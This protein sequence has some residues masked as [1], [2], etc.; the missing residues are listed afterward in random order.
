MHSKTAT[1]NIV[2]ITVLGSFL[3]AAGLGAW[4]F[5]YE[6][7]E[8]DAARE[9]SDKLAA[10]LVDPRPSAAPDGASDYVRGM[11]KYFGPIR[12]AK[13]VDVRQVDNYGQSSNTA[14]DRSWWTSTIFMRT[15]RGA[16]LVLLTFADSFDP[17][18]AKVEDIREL[19]PRKVAEGALTADESA[20]VKRAFASRGGKTAKSL[21]LDGT[22]TPRRAGQ[23]RLKC[24]QDANQDIDKL[25]KC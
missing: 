11:R 13:T 5:W 12:A 8:E 1:R 23:R 18:D 9:A 4:I 7:N 3:F 15:E 25:K 19:S 14:D 21:V 22:F 24:V 2:I 6:A 17:K 10:A 16:A 20:D